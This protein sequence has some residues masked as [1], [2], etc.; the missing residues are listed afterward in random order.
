MRRRRFM[1]GNRG[2]R[3]S[4]ES[5][6]SFGYPAKIAKTQRHSRALATERV[7]MG[8]SAGVAKPDT[9]HR[10][11]GLA[12]SV[13]SRLKGAAQMFRRFGNGSPLP[14]RN[15]PFGDRRKFS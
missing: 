15:N 11:G 9:P 14:R 6:F 5:A 13:H 8:F 1:R 4:I 2:W 3:K 7:D 10:A 12:P